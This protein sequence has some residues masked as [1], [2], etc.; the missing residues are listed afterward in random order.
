MLKKFFKKYDIKQHSLT[1]HGVHVVLFN[2]EVHLYHSFHIELNV[3]V[4]V[5]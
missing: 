1:Q 3:S 4:I 2:K 5:R